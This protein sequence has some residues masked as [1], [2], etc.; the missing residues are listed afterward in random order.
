MH[1][2]RCDRDLVDGVPEGQHCDHFLVFCPGK[3][4][5]RAL[6]NLLIRWQELGY[7]RGLE[8]VPMY[9]G[10][11]S[12][13][14]Q[15]FDQPVSGSLVHGKKMPYYM[16]KY[17]VSRLQANEKDGVRVP[18]PTA[19]AHVR[20]D[21]E[22]TVIRDRKVGLTT[23]VNQRG[24]TLPSVA[25]VI[26]TTGVRVCSPNLRSR[27]DVNCIQTVSVSESPA[28]HGKHAG[29]AVHPSKCLADIAGQGDGSED[30]AL[31]STRKGIE[32]LSDP[33]RNHRLDTI[34]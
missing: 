3:P 18:P 7:T 9:S 28:D 13:T 33:F 4:Q 26:S 19:K 25:V 31:C 6:S 2:D 29:G 12:E 34:G 5:T 14:W 16:S 15:Y 1:H 23:N 10:E 32:L 24:P 20:K 8:V 17:G 30:R 22:R 21:I 11:S 27:E